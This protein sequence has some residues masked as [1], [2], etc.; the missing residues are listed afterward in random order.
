MARP[1]Q[2]LGQE[3]VPSLDLALVLLGLADDALRGLVV[4]GQLGIE[5]ALSQAMDVMIQ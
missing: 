4:R 1:P 3:V 2:Q 5:E